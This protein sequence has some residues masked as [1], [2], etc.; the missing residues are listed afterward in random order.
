[1]TFRDPRL[2]RLNL[3]PLAAS[4]HNAGPEMPA[5]GH[6]LPPGLMPSRSPGQALAPNFQPQS[7]PFAVMVPGD[8]APDQLMRVRGFVAIPPG[9]A[10]G[11]LGNQVTVEFPDDGWVIGMMAI[12]RADGSAESQ[13]GLRLSVVVGDESGQLITDGLLGTDMPFSFCGT[14]DPDWQPLGRRVAR[15]ERWTF[16]VRNVDPM[17]TRVPDVTLKWRSLRSPGMG[18]G[19]ILLGPELAAQAP[20]VLSETAPD[21]Y[22]RVE[23]F[24]QIASGV[25]GNTRTF[26][27][28]E[29]GYVTAL[30]ASPPFAAALTTAEVQTSL[31]LQ[32]QW[33]D[34]GGFLTTDGQAADFALLS[35]F[36]VNRAHWM[37]YFRA[38]SRTERYSASLFNFHPTDAIAAPELMFKFRSV[39]SLR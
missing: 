14:S 30:L 26:Q 11:P 16:Q 13:Q 36:G 18:D 8:S 38:V 21:R 33:G 34:N 12:A 22:L 24:Q 7:P 1:M 2:E 31:G 35:C 39:R 4:Y 27:F 15:T 32:L 17:A 3:H 25:Q 23:G 20:L 5:V 19:P 29:D 37:P 10:P 6:G 28:P 9:P